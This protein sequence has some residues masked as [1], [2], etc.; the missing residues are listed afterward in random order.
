M[1]SEQKSPRKGDRP[2]SQIVKL[3]ATPEEVAKAIFAG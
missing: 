1:K 3:D 2:I